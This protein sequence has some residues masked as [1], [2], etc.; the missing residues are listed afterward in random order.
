M[1]MT[2]VDIENK[3]NNK[4]LPTKD[5]YINIVKEQISNNSIQK[6]QQIN[7]QKQ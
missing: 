3:Y 2:G 1:Y 6:I 5:E 7:Q 4:F